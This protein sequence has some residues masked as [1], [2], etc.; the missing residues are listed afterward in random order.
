MCLRN[1]CLDHSNQ[2]RWA[3]RW[4]VHLRDSYLRNRIWQTIS[5]R[6][7]LFT[8][9]PGIRHS[10]F[11]LLKVMKQSIPKMFT[12]PNKTNAN[13]T[14]FDRWKQLTIILVKLIYIW[15]PWLSNQNQRYLEKLALLTKTEWIYELYRETGW[16]SRKKLV[17]SYPISENQHAYQRRKSCESTLYSWFS[18]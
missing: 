7:V 16:A 4:G 17:R 2:P 5:E 11:A 8:H 9:R 14:K 6:C 18:R 3:D 13:E 1:L 12:T 10:S 15:I